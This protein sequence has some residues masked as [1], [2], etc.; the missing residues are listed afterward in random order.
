MVRPLEQSFP[1]T[2]SSPTQTPEFANELLFSS[3][4]SSPFILLMNENLPIPLK[5]EGDAKDQPGTHPRPRLDAQLSFRTSNLKYSLFPLARTSGLEL[6]FTLP[7]RSCSRSSLMLDVL[8]ARA[9]GGFGVE[10]CFRH[11]LP[12]FPNRHRL[13]REIPLQPRLIWQRSSFSVGRSLYPLPLSNMHEA[14]F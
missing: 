9:D 14:T 6:K 4:F 13:N 2:P 7:L 11:Y 10:P 8:A 5:K 3:W 12:V 1:E